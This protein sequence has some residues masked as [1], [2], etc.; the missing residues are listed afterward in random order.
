M[1]DKNSQSRRKFLKNI[2]VG[3]AVLP[4]LNNMPTPV[5]VAQTIPDKALDSSD[6]MASNFGYVMD[7]TK[8]DKAKYPKYTEGQHCKVCALFLE[9]GKT[10]AGQTGEFGRCGLFTNGLVSAN[11]WCNSF[12]PKIA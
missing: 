10:V 11:G 5:A 7:N 6:P 9:G 1:D 4:I 12:V 3:A 8:A 2:L